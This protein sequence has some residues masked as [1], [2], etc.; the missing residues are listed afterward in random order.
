MI[1]SSDGAYKLPNLDVD[2]ERVECLPLILRSA[3]KP[4]NANRSTGRTFEAFAGLLE[5][6]RTRLDHQSLP[7]WG[8]KRMA[9][10]GDEIDLPVDLQ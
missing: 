7:T 1:L 6:P 2:A 10:G 9:G 3:S 5:H 8:K 4:K